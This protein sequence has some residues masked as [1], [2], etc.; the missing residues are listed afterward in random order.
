[1]LRMYELVSGHFYLHKWAGSI[2]RTHFKVPKILLFLI[3]LVLNYPKWCFWA[4]RGQ[5]FTNFVNFEKNVFWHHHSYLSKHT[6]SLRVNHNN[7]HVGSTCVKGY[8]TK[9]F[10]FYSMHTLIGHKNYNTEFFVRL[11]ACIVQSSCNI[12]IAFSTLSFVGTQIFILIWPENNFKL[13]YLSWK[14]L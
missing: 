3:G 2:R 12:I 7:L 10:C 14:T 1:M 9:M 8:L 13:C 6:L 11:W 5:T 4:I